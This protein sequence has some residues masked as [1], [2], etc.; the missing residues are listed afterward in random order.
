VKSD[1]TSI[2]R[3]TGIGGR[4]L[5]AFYG[6]A[7]TVVAI[8]NID[9][10]HSPVLAI[11]SVLLLYVGLFVLGMPSE[12]P[13]GAVLTTIV[14]A[15]VAVTTIVSAWNIADP[16]SPGYA[17]WHL[18][19]MTFLLLVLALRGRPK[20]AWLGYGVFAVI[21]IVSTF[22][23]ALS[24]AAVATDIARQASSL[25]IG[26]LFAMLLRRASRTITAIQ[27]TQLSRAAARAATAAASGERERQVA[28]LERDARPALDRILSGDELSTEERTGFALLEAG[29]RDGIRAAG[30]SG[31]AIAN[32]TRAARARGLHVVLLDDRGHELDETEHA[33][34]EAALISEL[35]ATGVGTVTAR[36]SPWGHDEI[37]TI[38]VDEDGVFRR[39]VVGIEGVETTHL[40]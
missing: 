4:V 29:L 36:L 11:V 6:L 16:S 30:F 26:S 19:A 20:Q 37:G 38:V 22:F 34:I 13:F 32:E 17:N 25:L 33:L 3:L 15:L 14:I 12:E 21:E 18:G 1:V 39:S 24:I 7:T 10:Y 8:L 5:L 40:G 31:D 2:L 27:E 28:R 9:E 23:T 35:Q